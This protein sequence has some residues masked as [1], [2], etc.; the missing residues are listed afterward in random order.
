[1]RNKKDPHITNLNEDSQLSGKLYYS[2]ARLNE[3]ISVKIG[4]QGTNPEIVLRGVGIQNNH[5]SFELEPNGI[6]KLIVK[7]QEAWENTLVN[8]KR[9]EKSSGSNDDRRLSVKS[10][11]LLDFDDS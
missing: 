7:S 10:D 6:I 9:L 1:M 5:A 3:Q 8:G 11:N 4:R 2:L